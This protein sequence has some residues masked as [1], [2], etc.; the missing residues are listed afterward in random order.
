MHTH[1]SLPVR[2]LLW[3]CHLPEGHGL[4][5]L[6]APTWAS[7]PSHGVSTHPWGKHPPPT[8][9]DPAAKEPAKLEKCSVVILGAHQ[10]RPP[11][12][13]L[14]GLVGGCPCLCQLPPG[15]PCSP[16]RSLQGVWFPSCSV[17]AAALCCEQEKAGQL[18]PPLHPCL[19]SWAWME[20]QDPWV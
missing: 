11:G 4:W 20:S 2:A 14:S 5:A 8:K 12:L 13:D 17:A 16:G 9:C 19:Y 10:S 15:T 18:Y 1:I 3:D 7:L 6:L